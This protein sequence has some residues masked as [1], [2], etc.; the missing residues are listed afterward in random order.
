MPSVRLLLPL[1]L[2]AAPAWAAEGGSLSVEEAVARAFQHNPEIRKMELAAD[3]ARAKGREALAAYLPHLSVQATHFL[4]AD[5]ARLNVEFGGA[6]VAFPEGFPQTKASLEA[7]WTLFD[8]LRGWNGFR[9]AGL[10]IEAAE[11]ELT[12]ARGHLEQSVKVRFYK[13]LAAQ[14]LVT[15]A[16]QNIATLEEHAQ[17]AQAS[18]RAGFATRVDLLRI[19]SQLEE[20]RAEKLLAEDNAALARRDLYQV[21]GAEASEEPLEG[22][23]PLPDAAKA[24]ESLALDLDGRE[25]LRAQVKRQEALEAARRAALAS[26]WAPRLSLFGREEFYKFGAFDP[27]ILADDQFRS[28]YGYGLRLSWD[29]F[30]GFSDQAHLR[31]ASNALGQ[32]QESQ[33]RLRLTAAD[34]FEADK[35]R[36]RYNTALYQ[37]RLRTVEKSEESVRLA[38]LGVKAGSQTNAQALD[39]EL[40]LFRARA[41]LIQAQVGAAEARASLELA[42]GHGL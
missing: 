31:Q 1:L 13:A 27:A 6:A 20:A 18:E 35:R 38:T 12:H 29:L 8:G 33:R 32:A 23:L 28:S 19:D 7:S 42:L 10:E 5:Y 25:D 16:T 24:P 14:Q 9:E 17:L 40:D 39:A 22:S 11:L 4:D 30:N 41:G 3:S 21:L 34:D 15:V 37:A 36:Y 2:L 26:L